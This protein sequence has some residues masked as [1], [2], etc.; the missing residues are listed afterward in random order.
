M[1]TEQILQY[2]H[3]L[4]N[5]ERSYL[6]MGIYTRLPRGAVATQ[7]QLFNVENSSANSR[8]IG[9]YLFTPPPRLRGIEHKACHTWS[10]PQKKYYNI[11][12]SLNRA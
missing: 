6:T 5:A 7:S 11:I 10:W 8:V 3:S 4:W 2:N 12:I 1:S 9:Q